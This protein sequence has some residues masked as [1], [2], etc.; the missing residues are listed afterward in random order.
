MTKQTK[1]NASKLQNQKRKEWELSC[2]KELRSW[3]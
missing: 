2:Q 3:T 1:F